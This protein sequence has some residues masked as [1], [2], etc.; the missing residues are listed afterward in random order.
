VSTF[1]NLKLVFSTC[2]P[3]LLFC[4]KKLRL[5]LTE[6]TTEDSKAT[7]SQQAQ[8]NSFAEENQ[9]TNFGNS[10]EQIQPIKEPSH[11]E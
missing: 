5:P 7:S 10:K 3:F 8:T 2:V 4:E 9:N 11:S 6:R 1:N